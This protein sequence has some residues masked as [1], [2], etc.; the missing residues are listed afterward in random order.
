MGGTSTFIMGANTLG[1]V[2]A[3]I[4]FLRFWRRTHDYL[5]AAFSVAFFL[6]AANQA[7]V[8]LSGI[9][10]EDQSA[11]YLLRLSGYSLLIAA[12]I[13]KNL[14]ARRTQR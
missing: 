6:F 7:L 12:V 2:I 1:F 4:F 13:G 5:F 8:A 10:R 3:G 11:I 14:R 9:P